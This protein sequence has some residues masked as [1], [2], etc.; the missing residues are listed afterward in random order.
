MS[1]I[2]NEL[3]IGGVRGDSKYNILLENLYMGS[4]K[5]WIQ[6]FIVTNSNLRA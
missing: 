3:I 5:S 4:K 6:I 2:H 1:S